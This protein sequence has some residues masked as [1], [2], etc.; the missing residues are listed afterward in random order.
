MSLATSIL[1]LGIAFLSGDC[2]HGRDVE[3]C[4]AAYDRTK[5]SSC[6]SSTSPHSVRRGRSRTGYQGISRPHGFENQQ[7]EF[8][9]LAQISIGNLSSHRQ[10]LS[11]V[12]KQAIERGEAEDVVRYIREVNRAKNELENR[13]SAIAETVAN[14]ITAETTDII[15]QD[16]ERE[17]KE[18]ID[19]LVDELSTDRLT[20]WDETGGSGSSKGPSIIDTFPTPDVDESVF[21]VRSRADIQGEDDAHTALYASQ[22]SGIE[23]L[24]KYQAWGFIDIA[25]EPDYFLIYLSKPFQHV[26]YLGIVEQITPADHF[27]AEHDIEPDQYKFDET[28]KVIEFSD[29][30]RLEDPIPIGSDNPHRMQGLLYTTLG[31]VKTSETTDDL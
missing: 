11:A 9:L 2:Q 14:A 30:F 24:S 20:G 21:P 18:L 13:K 31:A 27:V 12:S 6:P 10:T 19:R 23:F 4:D 8:H 28:K 16:V 1:Q 26:R 22:E 29:L 25:R 3:A 7:A 15:Y 5:A 17:A